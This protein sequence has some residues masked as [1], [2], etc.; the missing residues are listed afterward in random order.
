MGYFPKSREIAGT[1]LGKL[2]HRNG[3]YV[4]NK[5]EEIAVSQ[6]WEIN[7]FFSS[8]NRELCGMHHNKNSS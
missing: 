2:I 8:H 4:G 6:S 1:P 3:N 7:G 5:N